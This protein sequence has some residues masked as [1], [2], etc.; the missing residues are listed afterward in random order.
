MGSGTVTL[1]NSGTMWNCNNTS[2]LTITANTSTIK[3][4]NTSSS[5]VTFA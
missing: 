5:A 3:F 2:N 4:T 1:S